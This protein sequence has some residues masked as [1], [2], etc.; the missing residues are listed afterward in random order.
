MSDSTIFDDV[1]RTIQERLPKLLIPLVNEVFHT[2]YSVDT[3]V[4]R[5]PEEYQK[6]LSK[7]IA[8]S[9]NQI[10]G[11]V[12][13]FECQSRTDGSM[14]LR[15]VEYDFM[16]A[17][18]DSIK[19]QHTNELHFPRSC[20]IYLRSTKNTLKEETLQI[21]FSDGQKITY[22]VPVLKL[23]NYSIN[24]IFE[25]NLLIL[26][27]YYIINYEKELSKIASDAERCTQLVAEYDH[28]IHKLSEITYDDDTGLF[29][30]I[31]QMMR[32]VMNY[33]LE[34]E[35]VL[36]ERIGDVM[37]GKVLPL[38]SDKLREARAEGISEGIYEGKSTV[39]ANMLK[40]CIP[41]EDICAIAE[42]DIAFVKQ[43]QAQIFK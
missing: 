3:E 38:P 13:H 34:K 12:Y 7:V 22:K 28:I 39:I 4:V 9:C 24:E 27:P 43:I 20:I 30:D 23:K 17:L 37:G 33:L 32:R 6:L 5:L 16:I 2:S 19:H 8:D 36:Q 21:T 25:K 26:L 31:L 35:P 14:V 15:M 11:L 29:H 10:D 1:L 40:R 41:I 18:S 42:C